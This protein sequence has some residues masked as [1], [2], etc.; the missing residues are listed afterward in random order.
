MTT[1]QRIKQLRD[2]MLSKKLASYDALIKLSSLVN[3]MSENVDKFDDTNL[4]E[5]LVGIKNAL[6]N[7]NPSYL[8]K[9]LNKIAGIKPVVNVDTDKIVGLLEKILNKQIVVQTTEVSPIKWPK[10]PKDAIPVVLTDK[11]LKD[12]YNAISS[13]PIFGGGGGVDT[14]K[15]AT[16]DLQQQMIEAIGNIEIDAVEIKDGVTDTRAA[17]GTLGLAVD[18]QPLTI[19]YQDTKTVPTVTATAI[20]TTQAVHSVTIKALSTNTVAVFIGGTGVTTANGFE[21]LAGE[22]VSLDVSNL[23]TV[24]C[25]SGSASQ[26]IRYIGI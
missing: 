19:I 3:S 14:S 6:E 9:I 12:F 4:S 24:F 15:L 7:N 11:S 23:A 8:E 5:K 10:K 21:L 16:K 1:Q 18:P 22:S 17:V 20:A 13:M 2:K 25:I 26:N